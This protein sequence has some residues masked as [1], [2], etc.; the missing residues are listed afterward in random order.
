MKAARFLLLVGPAWL[1]AWIAACTSSSSSPPAAADAGV[2]AEVDA[3][4]SDDGALAD[5]DGGTTCTLSAS[6]GS[7]KCNQCMQTN[8]CAPIGACAGDPACGPLQKCV[9]DCLNVPDAGGCRSDCLA[10]Y[11][12]G[13]T[14]W[15]AVEK[16]WFYTRKD[17]GGCLEDCTYQP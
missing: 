12:D 7:M 6:Y 13:K 2:D 11:P 9:T 10:Q 17:A 1:G 16:C 4:P 14:G 5:A 3:A 8:C 15:D